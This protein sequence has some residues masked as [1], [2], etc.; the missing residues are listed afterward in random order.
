MTLLQT[1]LHV[2]N[3]KNPL[4]RTIVPGVATAFAIQTAFGVPSVLAKT[5]RFYD[6]SGSLTHLAVTALSLYL[7]ALRARAAA[8][9]TAKPAGALPSLLQILR[10]PAAAGLNWRQV[11]LSAAVSVWAARCTFAPIDERE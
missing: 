7:P 8:V 1:L 4:L 11:A 9:G 2:T 5:E 3:F 6:F 10:E